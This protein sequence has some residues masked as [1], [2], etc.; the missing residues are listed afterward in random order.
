MFHRRGLRLPLQVLAVFF[1]I[2]LTWWNMGT[3]QDYPVS[4]EPLSLWPKELGLD[5]LP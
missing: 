2:P 5:P 4:Q 3:Y 1:P